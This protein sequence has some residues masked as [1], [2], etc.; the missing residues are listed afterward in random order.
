MHAL[1]PTVVEIARITCAVPC[2]KVTIALV[3]VME[4]TAAECALDQAALRTALELTV[5]IRA[6]VTAVHRTAKIKKRT[7]IRIITVAAEIVKAKNAQRIASEILVA[8]TLVETTLLKGALEK[9]AV[10]F[11]WD[12]NAL[13]MQLQTQTRPFNMFILNSLLHSL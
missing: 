3:L 6:S 2:V 11:A 8:Y 9:V 5:D 10:R 1:V 4:T 12:Q 7:T 13:E